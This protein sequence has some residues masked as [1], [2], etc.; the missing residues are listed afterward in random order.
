MKKNF[1]FRLSQALLW[2]VFF[3]LFAGCR[4]G[5]NQLLAQETGSF[6]DPRDGKVYKTVRIGDQWIL[7][8]NFVYKPDQGNYWAYGNDTNKDA[9]YGYLYDWE[10]ANAIAPEGWDL[11]SKEEWKTFRKS[12][13]GKRGFYKYM[14]VVYKQMIPGGSS[15]FDAQFGGLLDCKGE[16]KYLGEQTGFWSSTD[17][18]LDGPGTLRSIP[19]SIA[20]LTVRLKQNM[21]AWLA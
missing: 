20:F 8:E 6:T 3:I 19:T 18:R 15:G 2:V 9:L 11:P 14:Q 1:D 21:M 7:A 13:G 12:L 17:T 4:E 5:Q 16:F 10:T